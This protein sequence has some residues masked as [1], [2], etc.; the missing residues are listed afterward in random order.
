[1]K[2]RL[3]LISA[4]ANIIHNVIIGIARMSEHITKMFIVFLSYVFTFAPA[5][6]DKIPVK[7]Y[8]LTGAK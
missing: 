1:S 5:K 6:K 8:C 3:G 2:G 7:F 4:G